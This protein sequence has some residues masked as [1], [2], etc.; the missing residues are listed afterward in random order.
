MR[1]DRMKNLYKYLLNES[2][3]DDE[4]ED[5]VDDIAYSNILNKNN[6][7]LFDDALTLYNIKYGGK[8]F[9][10]PHIYSNG[11]VTLNCTQEVA[12]KKSFNIKKYI[13]EA[14]TVEVIWDR[15]SGYVYGSWRISSGYS[16]AELSPNTTFKNIICSKFEVEDWGMRIKDINIEIKYNKGMNSLMCY[17]ANPT[18]L[19][20]LNI[21][22]QESTK[23]SC[24]RVNSTIDELEFK[25]IKSNANVLHFYDPF[26]FDEFDDIAAKIFEFPQTCNI[27][28]KNKG[29]VKVV[30]KNFKKVK[31]ICNNQKRYS[32]VE[33]PLLVLKKG[34]KL[35]DIVD[36]KGFSNLESVT[37]ADNN[38]E[39]IFQKEKQRRYLA[40]MPYSQM[41]NPPKTAD[42]FYV[43]LESRK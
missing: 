14:D 13:P 18:S 23:K 41:E 36:I 22:F 30:V 39:L 17:F 43:Y 8:Q 9:L 32:L 24:I 16:G 19:K 7:F 3:L 2:L 5:R 15:N 11:K 34:A 21:N 28:D 1:N 25:N 27:D 40:C 12:Q 29:E 33:D 37:F 38:V 26:M 35:S 31:A 42:G 20:N 6:R 10:E 4:L